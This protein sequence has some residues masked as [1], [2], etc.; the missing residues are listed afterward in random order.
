MRAAALIAILIGLPATAFASEGF[1]IVIPGRPGVPV[2]INGIDAS[3]A[4]IEG[5][6]PVLPPE[7]ASR[8]DF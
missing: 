8:G 1:E 6:W 4:V 3:Y 5:D 7:D 2:I